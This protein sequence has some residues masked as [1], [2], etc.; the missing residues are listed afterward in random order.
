MFQNQKNLRSTIQSSDVAYVR[1]VSDDGNDE[2]WVR[3]SSEDLVPGDVILIP[4]NGGEMPCDAI[5]LFGTAIGKSVSSYKQKKLKSNYSLYFHNHMMLRIFCFHKVN[6]SMLT[7]E[8]V[9]ISKTSLQR[10]RLTS[11]NSTSSFKEEEKIYVEKEHSKHTLFRGT[12][13][14]Q[15]RNHRDLDT[16]AVVIRTGK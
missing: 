16:I 10:N 7:G 12:Q 9:P 11:Y 3:V 4:P 8:S 2:E 1:R 13:V 15:T 14:I 5:L 6:E